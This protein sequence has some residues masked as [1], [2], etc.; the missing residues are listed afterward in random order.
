MVHASATLLLP[1]ANE[2]SRSADGT[3]LFTSSSSNR[4]CTFVLPEDLL[5]PRQSPLELAAHG[6]LAL[7]EPT[8]AIAP[9]PYFALEHPATQVLL[10]A[11]TDHPIH[12]HHAFPP[13]PTSSSPSPSPFT[14]PSRHHPPAAQ[15]PPLASF[16]LIKR[17]TEAY[18]PVASLLW[19][20]PGAHFVAGTTNLLAVYDVSRPGGSAGAATPLLSVPTIPSTRHLAK[21]GGVGMRGTVA[22]LA[23]QPVAAA[24]EGWWDAAG[25]VAAGTWTRSLGLYDLMRAG[26]ECVATWSVAGAAREGGI[27]GKGVVQVVWSPCG[28]YLVVNERGATGLLVYDVRGMRRLL[29]CLEGRNGTTNQRLSCDVYRGTEGTGGFEVWAGAKDGGVVVWEGVGNQEGGVAPSWDWKAHD[30][31]VGSAAMHM[32][33]SVVA[34]CSGSWK[35]VDDE[36]ESSDG[37]ESGSETSSSTRRSPKPRVVVPETSLKI[38]SI[39]PSEPSLTE[40]GSGDEE[41]SGT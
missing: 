40:R 8:S 13:A 28:R 5:E 27:G 2:H 41:E 7:P 21:G 10:T 34:T 22:A 32:S 30:A 17:E 26:G 11:S 35:I 16:H 15:P 12:L 20:A 38:W 3:T 33:G 23:A 25:L 14:A 1:H 9:C 24:A 18:L 4:I 29:A 36:D 6:T 19:P 37:D 31:A 39:E